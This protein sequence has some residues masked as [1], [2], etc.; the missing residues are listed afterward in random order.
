MI[1]EGNFEKLFHWFD[2]F[3]NISRLSCHFLHYFIK[4]VWFTDT[5]IPAV[6]WFVL[7]CTKPIF[8]IFNSF[9]YALVE[10]SQGQHPFH[11]DSHNWVLR[12]RMLWD[13]LLLGYSFT[14]KPYMGFRT[15]WSLPSQSHIILYIQRLPQPLP[16]SGCYWPG[17]NP[18]LFDVELATQ[19]LSLFLTNQSNINLVH[20][21]RP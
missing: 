21:K 13:C 7:F 20:L 2:F 14:A 4:I 3:F 19:S 18:C 1:L 9:W 10:S 15:N 5:V 12:M 6:N 16:N 8:F 11:T 17:R